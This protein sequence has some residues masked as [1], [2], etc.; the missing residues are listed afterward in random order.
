MLF[1]LI[2]SR[3]YLHF[4]SLNELILFLNAHVS[5]TSC[6]RNSHHNK[7]PSLP[8]TQRVKNETKRTA[9]KIPPSQKISFVSETD[10]QLTDDQSSAAE[11]GGDPSEGDRK[12]KEK[13]KTQSHAK[14]FSS[15]EMK[16]TVWCQ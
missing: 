13:K 8:V 15:T 14:S 5:F 12:K 11:R 3:I 1:S 7:S 6:P 9:A 4:V 16:V 2:S 10:D